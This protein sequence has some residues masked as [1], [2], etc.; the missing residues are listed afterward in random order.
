MSPF[1]PRSVFPRATVAA[2]VLAAC[3][4]AAAATRAD[5]MTDE[6]PVAA[7]PRARVAPDSGLEAD[8]RQC[9][10]NAVD[11]VNEEDLDGF[12]ACF[13]GP[14]K[15]KL[16]KQAALRF[17]QHDVAMEL[18]DAQVL[19]AGQRTGEVAVKYRLVLSD[20]RF[21]VV[22][23]VAVKRDQGYWRIS[24]EKIQ[25][26]EHQSPTSCSPSR[27]ACLGGTCRVVAGR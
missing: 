14:T 10:E 4:P 18:L 5:S 20:D 9:L 13:T 19:E 17:V 12:C 8:I 22:A 7:R 25:S 15:S 2:V 26:F 27:Y 21:D 23:L 16:R 3:L 24:S 11:A 1:R 6:L